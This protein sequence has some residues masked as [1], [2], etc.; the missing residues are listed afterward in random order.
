MRG[1][2]GVLA[3]DG[4][5]VAVC[6]TCG[7]QVDRY[8]LLCGIG[9]RVEYEYG[10]TSRAIGGVRC[11]GNGLQRVVFGDG[12]RVARQP[13]HLRGVLVD[14]RNRAAVHRVVEMAEADLAP[15]IGKALGGIFLAAECACQHGVALRCHKG[16]FA[17][18]NACLDGA[19]GGIAAGR[20]MLQVIVQLGQGR[21]RG[22]DIVKEIGK[23]RVDQLLFGVRGGVVAQHLQMA[24]GRTT[25]VVADTVE[26]RQRVDGVLVLALQVVKSCLQL[27]LILKAE[28]VGVQNAVDQHAGAVGSDPVEGVALQLLFVGCGAHE[29]IIFHAALLENERQR[30]AV[31]EAVDVIADLGGHTQRVVEVALR[32][33]R[34]TSKAFAGGEIAVGLHVPAADDDKATL[35]DARTDLLEHIGRE[36]LD[37]AVHGGG[38]AD[39]AEFGEL[40]HTIKRG[41]DGCLCLGTSLLPT[42]LP[43][44]VEMGVAHQIITIHGYLLCTVS[45]CAEYDINSI[46]DFCPIV[47]SVAPFF[48]NIWE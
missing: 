23:V 7:L 43:N 38:G 24:N 40:F 31:T 8:H 37:P 28:A 39:E 48:V 42:P 27:L 44:G 25:T 6:H 9:V 17:A 10:Q 5:A 20:M 34:L 18:A 4:G 36:L 14:G 2:D 33:K 30:S 3:D 45:G 21:A 29:D 47:N 22:A 13:Q 12:S 41:A 11:P 35:A 16:A 15:C 26:Q 1:R 19:D 46:T 32:V